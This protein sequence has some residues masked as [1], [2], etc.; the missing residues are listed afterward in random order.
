MRSTPT[1]HPRFVRAKRIAPYFSWSLFAAGLMFCLGSLQSFA[2]GLNHVSREMQIDSAPQGSLVY[3]RDN[4]VIFSFATEDR[5]NVS[6][7]HISKPMVT[8]VLAAEDRYFFK[9]SGMDLIG[10]ARAALVDLKEGGLKEGG[11]TITQQLVRLVALTRNRTVERKVREALLALRLERRFPKRQILEAYL[12]RIYLGDG[13]YGVEAA[14]RGYFGKTAADLTAPEAA[15]LAGIIRC[16]SACSP[17]TAPALAKLRRDTVLGEMH[18]AG[19][20][21]NEEYSQGLAAPVA[22]IPERHDYYDEGHLTAAGYELSQPCALYFV[23]QVRR[24]VM[25]QFGEGD[26]LRGGLR[27]YT[28]VDMKLQK[29]A[30]HAIADRLQQIDPL[31]KGPAPADLLGQLEGALVAIDPRTGEVL[32]L[33]GGRDFHLSPFNRATQARRQPGSAFK[34][35]LFA[36]AIEQGYTPSSLLTDLDTPINTAQGAWLPSGEHEAAT[37]TLRQALTVSSNRAAVRLM[38]LVGIGTTQSYARRLGISSPLPSAPSLAIGT[39][40]VSLLDLTSAYGAFAN[41]GIVAPPTIVRSIED[42]TGQV[43]WQR[44]QSRQPYRA[45]RP[46]TA[47]LMSS[48]L[49]D[50]INRGTGNRARTEGFKLPAAGK[51][52]TTDDYGDA[53]FIGYTPHLVAGV[54][55][56]YDDHKKIMD[57][58]FAGTVAVPAWARFMMKATAGQAPDWFHPPN[59]VEKVTVC[60]A[61]GLRATDSCALVETADG[62]PNVYEDYFLVGTAPYDSCP[63]HTAPPPAI[64]TVTF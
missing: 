38:Q 29:Q 18:V 54:W 7:D 61:T 57:R 14:A 50:V 20:L 45:V 44:S 49:A 15:L 3:D 10:V 63:G 34:P 21:S 46:G 43:V 5:T 55:L 31:R 17:R 24:E 1:Q 9:H 30:E 23:E 47:F 60:R 39:G 64:E 25:S 32:A 28:T 48:M 62:R 26:V 2:S 52:G 51:T 42:S 35:L 4:H 8:A 40:E 11:S 41:E 19:S 12:N 53:W 36:A 16:P 37:Y 33:V 13:H 27:I 22:L 59:D 56:G 58:G 6:L